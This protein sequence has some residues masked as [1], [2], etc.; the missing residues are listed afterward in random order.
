MRRARQRLTYA[1]V[2]ATIALFGVIAGGAAYAASKIGSAGIKRHAVTR[3]K[4]DAK[5]V[6]SGKI[7]DGAVGTAQLSPG[8]DGP[9]LVG[10]TYDGPHGDVLN[11]FNRA[12]EGAPR[13]ERE[14]TGTFAIY[15][16]GMEGKFS[17]DL[18]ESVTSL[19]GDR[20]S[21]SHTSC[22]GYC[23]PEHPVVTIETPGGA[24]IGS[25]FTYV[26]FGATAH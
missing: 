18:I 7:A 6:S 24:P 13:I 11:Y 5:A 23:G 14:S 19:N 3:P 8:A 17:T 9:A 2:V 4:L 22:S 21:L 12:G 1:N 26:A 10:M 15:F 25:S 20:V 16:P